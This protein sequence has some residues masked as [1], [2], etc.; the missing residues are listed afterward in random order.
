MKLTSQK[1]PSSIIVLLKNLDFGY[2]YI[3]FLKTINR[4]LYGHIS[5]TFI[6][7]DIIHLV[8]YFEHSI[9]LVISY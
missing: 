9:K 2:S 3:I 1:S 5:S 8:L 4:E 6:N 7:Q